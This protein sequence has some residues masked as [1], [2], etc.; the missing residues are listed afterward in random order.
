MNDKLYAM[1]GAYFQPIYFLDKKVETMR[2]A[3]EALEIS[4]GWN[5]SLIPLEIFE[6][7][8][9]TGDLMRL[10]TIH[11]VQTVIGVYPQLKKVLPANWELI[12]RRHD[13]TLAGI[14][15]EKKRKNAR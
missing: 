5:L 3:K 4:E 9:E 12:V 13:L 8:K 14:E 15:L 6:E 1:V 10:T 7:D 11:K 2:E